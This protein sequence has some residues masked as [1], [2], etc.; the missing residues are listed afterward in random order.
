MYDIE[1]LVYP[2]DVLH[3]KPQEETVSEPPAWGISTVV[4]AEI[5]GCR[6]SSAR[7]KL[8]KHGVQK[9]KVRRLAKPPILYWNR[10]QVEQIAAAQVREVSCISERFLDAQSVMHWLAVS[11]STLYRYVRRG[12]LK[13]LSVRYR[14][15][16]GIRLKHFFMR[17]E[18]RHLRYHLNA[19]RHKG[20]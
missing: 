8:N 9:V 20:K 11:R 15:G 1:G 3:E 7:G 13:S 14:T 2:E 4:A 19:L 17:D 18:V 5:L 16:S 10:Q 12:V 6:Q